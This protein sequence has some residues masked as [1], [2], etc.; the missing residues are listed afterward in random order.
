MLKKFLY[1]SA[2]VL[3]FGQFVEASDKKRDFEIT[4]SEIA[5][6]ASRKSPVPLI[7]KVSPYS[8]FGYNPSPRMSPAK[9]S[10][11]SKSLLTESLNNLEVVVPVRMSPF[12]AQVV[13]HLN[14]KDYKEAVDVTSEA[15][16]N[17][18]LTP[19]LAEELGNK[20][21]SMSSE[22]MRSMTPVSVPCIGEED[23]ELFNIDQKHKQEAF[24]SI[25][26]NVDFARSA[27]TKVIHD[28][29]DQ[30]YQLMLD[31]NDSSDEINRLQSKIT[32]LKNLK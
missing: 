18:S 13:G 14:R 30:C 20:I 4:Y 3:L 22:N 32:R 7:G 1:V 31:D 25:V 24:G 19:A 10:K 27:K 2:S 29:E 6:L 8:V 9:I 21:S 26:Q 12:T 11:G 15:T 23:L 5:V 28:L 17:R 16:R